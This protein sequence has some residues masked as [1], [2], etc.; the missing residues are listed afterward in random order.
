M[1]EKKLHIWVSFFKQQ[2]EDVNFPRWKKGSSRIWRGVKDRSIYDSEQHVTISTS[3]SRELA[4]TFQCVNAKFTKTFLLPDWAHTTTGPRVPSS[5]WTREILRAWLRSMFVQLILHQPIRACKNQ[6]NFKYVPISYA[7][8]CT[9]LL[10]PLVGQ[11]WRL[12]NQMLAF[13][14]IEG[15]LFFS[16]YTF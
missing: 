2:R 12:I 1:H 10:L 6:H 9:L 15:C 4:I 8:V 16:Q 3:R 5:I 13:C 11:I 14:I 7:R